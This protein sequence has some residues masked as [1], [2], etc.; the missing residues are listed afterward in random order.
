M[1]VKTISP[2]PPWWF[3]AGIAAMGLLQAAFTQLSGDEA[4]YWMYSRHPDLGYKDHPPVIGLLTGL[5]YGI[6]HSELGV[7]LGV[8]LLHTAGVWL[9]WR[10]ARPVRLVEFALLV[11]SIPL[12]QVYSF[13]ATPDAPLVFFSIVFLWVWKGFLENPRGSAAWWL[14]L[15]MAALLWSKYHGIVLIALAFLSAPALWRNKHWWMACG[16]GVVL[17]SPHIIW[18]AVND[19]PSLKFHIVE[20]A[21]AFEWK[22]LCNYFGGQLLVLNPVVP[23]C[24]AMVVLKGRA[25]D[26]FEK[27]LRTVAVGFLLLFVLT[28]FRGRVE[29]HW[30]AAAVPAMVLLLVKHREIWRRW[31]MGLLAFFAA[32]IIVVRLS[33]VFHFLPGIPREF[34]TNEQRMKEVKALAGS[35]PVCFNNSYQ[36]PSLYMFYTGEKAHCINDT[37]GGGAKNQY[38]FWNYGRYLHEQPFYYVL[39]YPASGFEYHRLRTGHECWTRR[40]NGLQIVN[41]LYLRTDE[42]HH[43]AKGGDQLVL[44]AE[45]TNHNPYTLHFDPMQPVMWTAFMNHKE[46]PLRERIFPV[47]VG[48]IPLKLDPGESVKVSVHLSV[49][50]R[51][52]SHR[53]GIA[54]REKALPYTFQSNWIRLEVE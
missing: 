1:N 44:P 3:L 54:V 48:G 26:P 32:V 50:E 15:A 51:A 27:S 6:L 28:A 40:E 46:G 53:L 12:L 38:Q 14:G 22:H 42:W 18:Q 39:S 17:F 41:R 2:S 43:H 9:L 52:G 25:A 30:T 19:L 34:Y 10:I 36:L 7:R 24:L 33:L 16:I 20:R 11:C 35:L 21:G 31:T 29:P 49:P 13:I 5:G 37:G 4:L 47:E 23:W 45:L 8:V